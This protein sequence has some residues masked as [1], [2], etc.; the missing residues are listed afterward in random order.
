MG[1]GRIASLPVALLTAGAVFLLA[2]AVSGPEALAA[3]YLSMFTLGP[4]VYFGLLW[5]AGRM[6]T[7]ALGA[8]ESASIGGSGLL[9][10]L[11]PALLASMAS[12]WVYQLELGA[13]QVQRDQA[14]DVPS[15]T[16][17]RTASAY[18]CPISA[19]C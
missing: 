8:G 6:T 14:A 11:L 16:A 15:P 4:L 7:P 12:P 9:M 3:F 1:T 19:K 13:H 10:V 2:R 18:C 5:L 17:S